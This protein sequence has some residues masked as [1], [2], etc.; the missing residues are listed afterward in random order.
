MD[1]SG[2]VITVSAPASSRSGFGFEALARDAFSFLQDDL[3]FEVIESGETRVRYESLQRFVNVYYGRSSYEVGVEVGRW[4]EIDGRRA[5]QLFPL[6]HLLAVE[7]GRSDLDRIRTATTGDQLARELARLASLLRDR[8][9][10]LLTDGDDLF[11]AMSELNTVLSESYLEDIRAA[12]LRARADDAW[13][14]RDLETVLLAYS[15]IERELATVT[16][17]ASERG[18]LDYARKHVDLPG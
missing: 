17:R 13:R 5:E 3:G 10:P 15:E 18:R 4:L 9:T 11:E 6:V 2:R 7:E 16:L 14:R 1:A 8:A 12:R